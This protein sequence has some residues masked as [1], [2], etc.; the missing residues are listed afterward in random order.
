MR[1]QHEEGDARAGAED[2]D[3]AKHMK[4]FYCQIEHQRF[5]AAAA[6]TGLSA[7]SSSDAA[8]F[9]PLSLSASQCP[10]PP[11]AGN[12]TKLTLPPA[13]RKVSTSC[14]EN[15]GAKYLS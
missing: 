2:H 6:R 3:G 15:A 11:W 10:S 14:R 13:L 5:P 4:I 7:R 9:T 1:H 8:S 12:A